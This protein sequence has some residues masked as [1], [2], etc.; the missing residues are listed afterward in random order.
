MERMLKTAVASP[1]DKVLREALA[2]HE[3]FRKLHYSADDIYIALNSG[4]KEL[5]ELIQ[6]SMVLRSGGKQFTVTIGFVKESPAEVQKLWDD[7]GEKWNKTWT[8][9]QRKALWEGS[10]IRK[11]SVA[12]MAAFVSKGFES[13]GNLN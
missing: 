10:S 2:T 6:I 5:K 1:V 8:E 11:N 4:P 7:L 9:E 13:R 12:F 3:A